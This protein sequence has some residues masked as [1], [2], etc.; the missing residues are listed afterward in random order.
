MMNHSTK[1]PQERQAVDQKQKQKQKSLRLFDL[2]ELAGPKIAPIA[3]RVIE[4]C[5]RI[6][7]D[8]LASSVDIAKHLGIPFSSVDWSCKSEHVIPFKVKLHRKWF[9][10]NENTIKKA[11]AAAGS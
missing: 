2:K 4:V 5:K 8:K 1:Q 7:D 10:G 9:Y 11:K 6:P 3:A